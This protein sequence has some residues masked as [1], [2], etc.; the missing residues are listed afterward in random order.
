[1][2]QQNPGEVLGAAGAS[3]G[4]RVHIAGLGFRVRIEQSLGV[5]HRPLHT[6]RPAITGLGF[7]VYKD[8]GFR[9]TPKALS[10]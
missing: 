1:M 8:L 2:I 5:N 4:A 10:P 3:L 7:R 9:E 6:R